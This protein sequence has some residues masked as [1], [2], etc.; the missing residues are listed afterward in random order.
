VINHS[1]SLTK[2]ERN[3]IVTK[4]K[5]ELLSKNSLRQPVVEKILNQMIN[6]VNAIIEKY[7]KPDE[8]RVELARELKQSKD[9]RNES[10]KQ[11]SSN[12]KLNDDQIPTEDQLDVNGNIFYLIGGEDVHHHEDVSL[13]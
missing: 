13:S 3:S 8:I 4:D 1:N 6:V 12:K 7:E 5:L 10:D 2:D 11:N 9:E